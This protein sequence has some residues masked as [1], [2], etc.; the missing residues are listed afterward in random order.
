[1]TPYLS[2]QRG[3]V[4]QSMM[5]R[6][7]AI[8][9]CT[10]DLSASFLPRA[11]PME[12][13]S[14]LQILFSRMLVIAAVLC[15]CFVPLKGAV[16]QAVVAPTCPQGYHLSGNQCVAGAPTPQITV[17]SSNEFAHLNCNQLWHA[18][19]E[20]FAEFGYCFKT[21]R[22]KRAFPNNCFPPYGKN[23]PAWARNDVRWI[24]EVESANRCR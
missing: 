17:A 6:R 18:R 1:M 13:K 8:S 15:A 22:A 5:I 16:A 20:I 12:G 4:R 19:N 7:G 21:A 2:F 3:D 10:M 14:V 9:R 24:K 23:L 11:D